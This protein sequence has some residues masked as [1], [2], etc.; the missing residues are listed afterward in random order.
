MQDNDVIVK[1]AFEK[2][3]YEQFNRAIQ[4]WRQ[5]LGKDDKLLLPNDI[6]DRLVKL[7]DDN[8]LPDI[9]WAPRRFGVIIRA[10]ILSELYRHGVTRDQVPNLKALADY[11]DADYKKS[12]GK[13]VVFAD[14]DKLT[15]YFDAEM[16]TEN[17]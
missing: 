1:R 8:L 16:D 10:G 15:R 13:K 14:K 2:Y 3:I 7:A 5:D 4:F 6:T 17:E 12:D 9:K 11:L